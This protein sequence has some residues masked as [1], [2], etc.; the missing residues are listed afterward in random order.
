MWQDA[1]FTERESALLPAADI[2]EWTALHRAVQDRNWPRVRALVA[3]GTEEQCGA[4]VPAVDEHGAHD[5]LG[6]SNALHLA[7]F[8]KDTNVPYMQDI[9]QELCRKAP[10][11]FMN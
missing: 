4:V 2:V 3:S 5:K 8:K 11:I 10:H 6:G 1:Q 9:L 7:A